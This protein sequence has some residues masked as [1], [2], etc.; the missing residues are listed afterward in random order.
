MFL[1]FTPF[2]TAFLAGV[3]YDFKNGRFIRTGIINAKTSPRGADIYLNGKIFDST[4]ATIRF[5]DEG[6]YEVLIKKP[7]YFD[8]NKRLH[9]KAQY[10]TYVYRD[11]DYVYLF[12]SQPET[13]LLSE[14]VANFQAGKKR[15]IY[16]SGQEVYLTDVNSP[17]TSRILYLPRVNGVNEKLNIILS[18][19][20]N[21]FLLYNSSFYGVASARDNKIFDITRLIPV[22]GNFS[23]PVS[24]EFSQDNKIILLANSVLYEILWAEQKVN[25]ILENV[26]SFKAKS[27]GIYFIKSMQKGLALGVVQ[28]PLYHQTIL[29][30]DLPKWNKVSIYITNQNQFFIIGDSTLYVLADKPKVIADFVVSAEVYDQAAKL[31]FAT[32]NEISLY[33]NFTGITSNVTRSSK[34]VQQP[35][36]LPRL[37][38]VFFIND[39]RLQNIETD[40]RDHRNNYTFA[41]AS[42]NA[43]YFV[44]QDGSKLFLLE[45]GRLIFMQIR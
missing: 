26:L 15:I 40:D 45:S 8:W 43:K 28:G 44:L 25:P 27:E 7:G 34:P 12:K 19:D 17:E 31:V 13:R 22:Q 20:E 11:F 6:D 38:W 30:S 5:V 33:D 9:V 42:D 1:I 2:I 21:Y 16:I 29:M 36:L 32:N 37:G 41:P 39:G 18:A 3:K 23:G 35:V 10:V 4:P 24:L 14:G